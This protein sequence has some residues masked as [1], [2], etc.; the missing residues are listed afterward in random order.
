M[1]HVARGHNGFEGVAE[2]L[3]TRKEDEQH[4]DVVVCWYHSSSCLEVVDHT[5]L[6]LI[7]FIVVLVMP[8]ACS[9]LAGERKE[10]HAVV[11]LVVECHH[12]GVDVFRSLDMRREQVA[13]AEAEGQPV[14]PETIL[15]SYVDLVAGVE[16]SGDVFFR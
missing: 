9:P 10:D 1:D 11:E 7:A 2:C 6:H 5:L 15:G 12:L 16:F 8:Q 3:R 13:A 4:G 14:F